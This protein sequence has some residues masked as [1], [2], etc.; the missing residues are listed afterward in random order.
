MK[1]TDMGRFRRRL[2]DMGIELAG[3]AQYMEMSISH[4]LSRPHRFIHLERAAGAMP[5][6]PVT[7]FIDC[8]VCRELLFM[9]ESAKRAVTQHDTIAICQLCHPTELFMPAANRTMDAGDIR[10]LLGGD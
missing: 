1:P 9:D 2:A 4:C 6:Y 5:D 7:G 3:D 10:R 8:I